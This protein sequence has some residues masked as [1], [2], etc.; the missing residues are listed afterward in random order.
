MT[1][2]L[3]LLALVA[4]LGVGCFGACG[5]GDGAHGAST[6]TTTTTTTTTTTS[7]DDGTEPETA[8]PRIVVSDDTCT[9]DADC[10]PGGCC[11][12]ATCVAQAH[13]PTCGDAVCT[14]ECRYGTLDC[15]GGCLCQA[16]HCAAR[17]SEPPV[18]PGVTDVQ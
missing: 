14:T 8:G 16:G 1:K 17:L 9:T 3:T 13:A 10:V 15:G 18:I 6:E 4:S 11:H 7:G 12:P 5:G 2:R